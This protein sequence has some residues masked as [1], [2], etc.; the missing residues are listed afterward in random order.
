MKH[1]ILA[2]FA[3]SDVGAILGCGYC[4]RWDLALVG[5]SLLILTCLAIATDCANRETWEPYK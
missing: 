3:W 2:S 1:F 4:S 5:I